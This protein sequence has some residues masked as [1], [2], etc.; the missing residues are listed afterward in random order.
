[1]TSFFSSHIS[2]TLLGFLGQALFASRFLVQWWVSER[3]KRVTVPSAFWYLS[4]CGGLAL[5]IYAVHRRD[6]VFVVG[7]LAGIFVYSRN[8]SWAR[9][10]ATA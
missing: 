9:R 8:L 10:G 1:M 7:Q 6:P 5:L 2:W 3:R 4:L